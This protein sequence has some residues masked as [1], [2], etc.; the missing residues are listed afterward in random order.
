MA[1]E[2]EGAGG[3]A[4]E[5]GAGAGA[6]AS[7]ID[8]LT[9][10]AAP[11]GGQ[12]GSGE[13]GAGAAGDTG[14]GAADPG[15]LDQLSAETPEGETASLRDWA[16][17]V[18]VKDLNQLAKIARDNQRALRESGRVKVPGEGARAEEVAAWRAA[19]GV[20]ETAEGY[21]LDPVTGPDG[22]EVPLDTALLGRLAA[23]AHEVGLPAPAYKA[24]V[25]DFIRA[26]IEQFGAMEAEQRSEAEEWVKAQGDKAAARSQAVNRGAEVLGLDGEEVLKVRNA[27]G[28]KRALDMLTRLGEGV[29]E[30]V[31]A[32]FGGSQRFLVSGDQAQADINAMM[33]DRAVAQRI[34]VKGSPEHAKYNRL[35]A[36]VGEAANRR[37]AAGG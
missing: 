30:D 13:G 33:A 2:N 4:G 28:S 26:Q 9:G 37:A 14:Q 31:V 19:I 18:G 24:I 10:G 21:Q 34:T 32:G 11:S 16:R 35:L 25:G 20:P 1:S 15:W 8:L 23:K 36:I 3:G 12:D 22:S 7:A 17:S 5:G 6:G 27:L 29:G